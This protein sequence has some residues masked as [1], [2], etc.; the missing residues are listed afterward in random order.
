MIDIARFY[1]IALVYYGHFIERI[2]YLKNPTAA[3][4][5]NFI[6]SFHM[7]LFFVL[8]GFIAKKSDLKFGFVNGI[9]LIIDLS[10]SYFPL[11]TRSR[12]NLALT[13]C[14]LRLTDEYKP[15]RGLL[16]RPVI[17]SIQ[18]KISSISKTCDKS[19]RSNVGF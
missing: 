17:A 1:G 4:H 15:V 5:Y 16:L 13:I 8:A 3:L 9:T 7:L 19:N 6:Y 18:V 10:F 12:S 14:P 11:N 2:M